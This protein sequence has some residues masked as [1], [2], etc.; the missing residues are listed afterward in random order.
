M[1]ANPTSSRVCFG[2]VRWSELESEPG[3]GVDMENEGDEDEVEEKDEEEDDS[4]T[5]GRGGMTA[6]LVS[7]RHRG[8]CE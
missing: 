6:G 3:V 8:E 2:M 4:S 7:L 1:G 5:E